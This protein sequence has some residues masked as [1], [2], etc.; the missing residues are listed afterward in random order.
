MSKT[1]V[2]IELVAGGEATFLSALRNAEGSL[3]SFSGKISGFASSLGGVAD[4]SSALGQALTFALGQAIYDT[5]AKIFGMGKEALGVVAKFERSTQSITAM[6]A[7]E[8]MRGTEVEQISKG[9]YKLTEKEENK[10]VDLRLQ[11]QINSAA[12]HAKTAALEKLKTATGDSTVEYSGQQAQVEKATIA[13]QRMGTEIDTLNAK[14]GMETSSKK[15]VSAGDAIDDVKKAF[16]EAIPESNL[17]IERMTKLALISPY[18]R[19]DTINTLKMAKGFGMTLNEAG[20]L[21]E[22]LTKFATVTGRTNDHI[23]RLAYAMGEMKSTG[24]VMMRQVRQMNL[25]GISVADMGEA[26]GLTAGEMTDKIHKGGVSFDEFG[27]KM[28]DFIN[29]KYGD[30]FNNIANSF[31]GLQ[32]AVEDIKELSLAAIFEGPLKLYKPLLEEFVAPF[33]SGTMLESIRGFSINVTKSFMPIA[34]AAADV[35]KTVFGRFET[36]AA[37]IGGKGTI[38][39]DQ[40]EKSVADHKTTIDGLTKSMDGLDKSGI[41]LSTGY[42]KL[43]TDGAKLKI[44]TDE[45]TKAITLNDGQMK[46]LKDTTTALTEKNAVYAKR[47]G[48][49]KKENKTNTDE[50]KSLNLMMADNTKIITDN[51]NQATLLAKAKSE[52]SEESR[53]LATNTTTLTD[54]IDKMKASGADQSNMHRDLVNRM[55]AE[56]KAVG[57]NSEAYKEMAADLKIIEDNTANYRVEMEKLA[58][59]DAVAREMNAQLK[60]LNDDNKTMPWADAFLKANADIMPVGSNLHTIF[61]TIFKI[62]KKV[63]DLFKSGSETDLGGTATEKF[64]FFEKL[65]GKVADALKWVHTNFDLIVT[66]IKNVVTVLGGLFAIGQTMGIIKRVITV[67]VTMLNP[68]NLV[69]AA[70]SIFSVAWQKN[71]YGIQQKFGPTVKKIK[72]KLKEITDWFTGVETTVQSGLEPA[73]SK[74]DAFR[75]AIVGMVQKIEAVFI[76]LKNT[77]IN[78]FQGLFS[79]EN[80]GLDKAQESVQAFLRQIGVVPDEAVKI[81]FALKGKLAEWKTYFNFPELLAGFDTTNPAFQTLKTDIAG[82]F[83]VSFTGEQ[84]EE[85][86]QGF[87]DKVKAGILTVFGDGEDATGF[88]AAIGDVITTAIVETGKYMDTFKEK[89]IEMKD[90]IIEVTKYVWVHREAFF[91]LA[92]VIAK[93]LFVMYLL[94]AANKLFGLTTLVPVVATAVTAL[95]GYGAALVSWVGTLIASMTGMGAAST[96]AAGSFVEGMG[97]MT[98]GFGSSLAGVGTMLMAF[99]TSLTPAGWIMMGV[100]ALFLVLAL[101]NMEDLAFKIMNVFGTLFKEIG[102]IAIAFVSEFSRI[103][104]K[105]YETIIKPAWENSIKPVLADIAEAFGFVMDAVSL[106]IQVV[107]WLITQIVHTLGPIIETL[108]AWFLTPLL[109]FFGLLWVGITGLIRIIWALI[110]MVV[111]AITNSAGW[112]IMIDNL[113]KAWQKFKDYI[114]GPVGGFFDWLSN[115]IYEQLG[116][117]GTWQTAINSVIDALGDMFTAKTKAEILKDTPKMIQVRD[118]NG[119]SFKMVANPEYAQLEQ[120]IADEQKEIAATFKKTSERITGE[121]RYTA[122]YQASQIAKPAADSFSGILD[123]LMG[124]GGSAGGLAGLLAGLGL[125]KKEP[126]DDEF[127]KPAPTAAPWTPGASQGGGYGDS[128]PGVFMSEEQKERRAQN[129]VNAESMARVAEERRLQGVVANFFATPATRTTQQI[130]INNIEGSYIASSTAAAYM[131]RSGN[132]SGA[133]AALAAAHARRAQGLDNVRMGLPVGA[134]GLGSP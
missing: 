118:T 90:K 67:V 97:T 16:R 88:A 51:Q 128:P 3:G 114:L 2:G 58:S 18:K 122:I 81:G 11:Y 98:I 107:G 71:W 106:L 92:V 55:A 96:V 5:G 33:T 93:V 79:Q 31:V 34:E 10:L 13:L 105:I 24:K 46:V 111:R 125:D 78:A 133:S 100:I 41:S 53:K 70:V 45:V 21:T 62:M 26:F 91:E 54:R 73:A 132:V 9:I 59:A 129:A 80:I 56:E 50:Y 66:V 83:K 64:S 74:F 109:S 12:L 7:V 113:Q 29:A 43:L 127:D 117:L 28:K 23:S 75:E 76:P 61:D 38:L 25:A 32:N 108:I 19:E 103:F 68:L 119:K 124:G 17:M 115:K 94:N 99:L 35:L 110:K 116:W 30:A 42:A 36:F 85:V 48:V 65:L 112:I 104:N 134:S 89:L 86:V 72:D 8:K 60:K 6:F 130:Q 44:E 126:G 52:L 123:S 4:Q 101:F 102:D 15:M 39:I 63:F 120:I 77:F 1:P 84:G 82:L 57:K 49:L 14:S 37:A 69:I 121:N 27:V 20:D 131:A 87:A 95:F 47:M 22:S 40:Q